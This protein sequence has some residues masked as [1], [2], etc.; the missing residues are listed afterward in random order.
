[1]TTLPVCQSARWCPAS[2]H[3]PLAEVVTFPFPL[4]ACGS[5]ATPKQA[6]NAAFPASFSIIC[7]SANGQR[8]PHASQ[9]AGRRAQAAPLGTCCHL[10]P[11]ISLSSTYGSYS[12]IGGE[13]CREI[14]VAPPGKVTKSAHQVS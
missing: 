1:M 3:L 10:N 14:L 13:S 4:Q 2:C 6:S 8:H 12:T 9:D 11:C 7:T 5:Q